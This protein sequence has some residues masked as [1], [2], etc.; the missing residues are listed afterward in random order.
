MS[1]DK[2]HE[3]KRWTGFD[4][5]GTLVFEEPEWR[6]FEHIGEPIKPIV[7]KLK[8][9]LKQ[10]RIVK[11][12]TARVSQ[13]NEYDNYIAR[14]NIYH[15]LLMYVHDDSM[16]NFPHIEIVSGKDMYMDKLY[17]NR[18]VQVETNTGR[19]IGE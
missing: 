12:V 16:A 9:Y 11:I 14:R 4:F 19:I 17:D 8:G 5:D 1:N 7:D 3:D 13:D 18:A 2:S 6:G 10:G 15:W